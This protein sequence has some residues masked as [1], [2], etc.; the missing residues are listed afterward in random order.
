MILGAS[1]A[2]LLGVAGGASVTA[3]AQ[4][5]QVSS[6]S[7]QATRSQ[8]TTALV[9]HGGAGGITR[10]RM[11]AA[12]R[13]AYRT[14]LRT[15]L[16]AGYDVL[17]NGGAALKAVEA[18]IVEMEANP[19]FNAGRG[20]VRTAQHTIELDAALMEGTTR[21]AGAVTGVSSV[22]HPIRGARAVMDASRHVMLAGAGA[23]AFA[24]EQG[25]E[26]VGQSYFRIERSGASSG[27]AARGTKGGGTVGAVALAAD[28]TLAA[29]TSTGGLSGK[30]VGR[31]GDSPIVGAGTYAH[32]ASVAVSATGQGEYFMRG[33]TAYSIAARVRFRGASVTAA[34]QAAVQEVQAMGGAGGVIVLGPEGTIAMPFTTRG[35]FRAAVAPNG[36]RMVRLFQS[37]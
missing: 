10:A 3:A 15:A 23:E 8:S 36:T 21:G 29:G 25:L 30:R 17:Q 28:G 5:G 2:V 33:V 18:A 37:P 24:A 1:W 22:K 19:L 26:R 11:T 9:I 14:G 12:Q 20:A 6:D 34:A 35:M 4:P 13:D 31:V 32:D 27:E 16:E 7:I